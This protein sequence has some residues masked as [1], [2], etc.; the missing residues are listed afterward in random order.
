[1]SAGGTV[2]IGGISQPVS[3]DVLNDAKDRLLA[4]K[5]YIAPALAWTQN[6]RH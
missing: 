6:L 1:M 5:S 3:L 2:W 4:V